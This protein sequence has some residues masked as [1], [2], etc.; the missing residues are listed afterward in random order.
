MEQPAE[1]IP[2]DDW[3]D[4]DLLTRDEASGRL[5]AEIE[6]VTR[7][8]ADLQRSADETPSGQAAADFLSKRLRALRTALTDLTPG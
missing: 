1:Q 2:A 4:Q 5:A 3:T 7:E 8:L 6:S